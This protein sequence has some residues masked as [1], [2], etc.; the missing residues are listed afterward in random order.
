[1]IEIFK[2]GSIKSRHIVA[3]HT[4]GSQQ[5]PEPFNFIADTKLPIFHLVD[6]PGQ[7]PAEGNQALTDSTVIGTYPKIRAR[8]FAHVVDNGSA[9]VVKVPF[10]CIERAI[11]IGR[12]LEF[13]VALYNLNRSGR[14]IRN[15]AIL[16][17]S[18]Y[19][20]KP[21]R[22]LSIN[23]IGAPIPPQSPRQIGERSEVLLTVVDSSVHKS[24][25]PIDPHRPV[26]ISPAQISRQILPSFCNALRRRVAP[27]RRGCELA[28]GHSGVQPAYINSR[29]I[30]Q[31]CLS[32]P[33]S[34]SGANGV[35]SGKGEIARSVA[36]DASSI[37]SRTDGSIDSGA[38]K[39]IDSIGGR[40]VGSSKG[41]EGRS[42]R[43]CRNLAA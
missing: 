5:C 30:D 28:H 41:G 19:F 13:S 9:P 3:T 33:S 37:D 26:I 27:K 25:I 43:G 10:G 4:I 22:N 8:E 36:R 14:L 23:S 16:L 11:A 38:S 40:S 32:V 29:L 15:F 2:L 42:G 24:I 18:R 21:V 6:P 34:E 1:M 7:Q 17:P 35:G 31:H 39:L 12:F 20:R